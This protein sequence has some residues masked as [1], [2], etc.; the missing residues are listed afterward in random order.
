MN[1]HLVWRVFLRCSEQNTIALQNR[2]NSINHCSG[3][4]Q[5]R[6]KTFTIALRFTEDTDSV[7]LKSFFEVFLPKEIKLT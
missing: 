1:K 4:Q 7:G 2:L 6:I 3:Y 5:A